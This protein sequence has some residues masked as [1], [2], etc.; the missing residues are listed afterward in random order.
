MFARMLKA[1]GEEISE[2]MWAIGK[3]KVFIMLVQ[4][5]GREEKDERER[6][7]KGR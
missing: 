5:E 6:R 4:R 3:N 7:E 1:E 2:E